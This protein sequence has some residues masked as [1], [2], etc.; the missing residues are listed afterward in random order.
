MSLDFYVAVP[1]KYLATHETVLMNMAKWFYKPTCAD[2]MLDDFNLFFFY[3]ELMF[4]IQVNK[5]FRQDG[6]LT[7]GC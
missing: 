1:L 7:W 5:F 3:L 2:N 6:M 4:D